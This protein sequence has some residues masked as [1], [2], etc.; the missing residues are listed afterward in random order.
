MNKLRPR[1]EGT[2]PVL[3]VQLVAEMGCKATLVCSPA[4]F[5]G[6]KFWVLGLQTILYILPRVFQA[7]GVWTL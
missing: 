6:L 1:D 5:H 2:C 7:L 3:S 4:T